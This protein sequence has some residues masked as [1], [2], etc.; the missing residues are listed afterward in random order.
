MQ[1][2]STEEVLPWAD[3]PSSFPPPTRPGIRYTDLSKVATRQV[4]TSEFFVL[5]HH[6]IP[7]IDPES[8]KLLVAGSDRGE[9]SLGLEEI[10]R[11]SP[12]RVSAALECAGNGP[13][14]VQGLVG[15]A[16]WE[17]IPLAPLLRELGVPPGT[18]EVVFV[19]ADGAEERLRGNRYP[20]RFARS[21]PL[22]DALG[23]TALKVRLEDMI[24]DET[25]HAE[26]ITRI[27]TNWKT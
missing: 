16:D 19:G 13:G 3:L 5:Q 1:G 21:L 2:G 11:R 26:E 4:P 27:L 14:G 17:G 18:R 23:E 20:S 9:V 8:W 24:V 15:S 6:E 10:E 12:K 25:H 7:R 22:A